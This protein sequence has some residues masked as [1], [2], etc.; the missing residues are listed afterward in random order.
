VSYMQYPQALYFIQYGSYRNHIMRVSSQ[1]WKNASASTPTMELQ[2]ARLLNSA[3]FVR[4]S[5]VVVAW[6]YT[7]AHPHISNGVNNTKT[8][9]TSR[10][11]LSCELLQADLYS[12]LRSLFRSGCEVH[13]SKALAISLYIR[14]AP[15]ENLIIRP[16]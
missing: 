8:L 11:E 2:I 6:A 3:T 16:C 4:S 1:T 12:I 7:P 14:A 10:P 9:E 13:L 5:V 15:F